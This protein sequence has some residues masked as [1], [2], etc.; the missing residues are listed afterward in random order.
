[1]DGSPSSVLTFGLGNGTFVPEVGL[2]LTLGLGVGE[3][4]NDQYS[5]GRVRIQGNYRGVVTI[6]PAYAGD[7]HTQ[8]AYAGEVEINP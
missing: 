3:A 8:P 7:V 2:V 5:A 6:E 1:M 4:S